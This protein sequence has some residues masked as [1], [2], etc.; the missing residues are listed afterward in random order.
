MIKKSNKKARQKDRD[1]KRSIF[2]CV[3]YS[4][5]WRKP[6][7]VTIKEAKEKFKL[8]WLRVGMSYH[9]FTNLREIF[10]GDLSKKLT[11]DVESK[12]FM[13]RECNCRLGNNSGCGYNDKCRRSVVVYKITCN[14]TGKVRKAYRF[15][16]PFTFAC[17][18]SKL[19]CSLADVELQLQ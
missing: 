2:F 19:S 9:R 10:Q 8:S 4:K 15:G 12:D 11:E 18:S 7:H 17:S 16:L 1:R 14:Q 6:I 13:T 5:A 3:G